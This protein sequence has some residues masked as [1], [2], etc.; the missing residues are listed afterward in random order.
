MGLPIYH[1]HLLLI[2]VMSVGVSGHLDHPVEDECCWI[3]GQ[4]ARSSY[5]CR[6]LY[7]GHWIEA[8]H[9]HFS[10]RSCMENLKTERYAR[11]W[12]QTDRG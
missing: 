5:G 2:G 1:Y 7:E 10:D 12:T 4:M 3:D 11:A 8:N 9:I 6:I